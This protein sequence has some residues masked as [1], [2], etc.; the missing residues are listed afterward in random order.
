M[1]DGRMIHLEY[2]ITPPVAPSASALVSSEYTL[3]PNVNFPSNARRL[4]L[5]LRCL[6]NGVAATEFEYQRVVRVYQF[7]TANL[8][9][10]VLGPRMMGVI[11]AGGTFAEGFEVTIPITSRF[12][13]LTMASQLIKVDYT[14]FG[15]T[16]R[17]FDFAHV[18]GWDL[19]P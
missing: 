14:G 19:G 6:I 7:A 4:K 8:I 18:V 15:Y 3:V 1:T 12:P 11:P 13:T 9:A 2:S 10:T 5:Y 17:T 16:S